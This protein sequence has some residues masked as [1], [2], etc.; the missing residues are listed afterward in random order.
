MNE[1]QLTK[2]LD[3][4]NYESGSLFLIQGPFGD[5]IA[6]LDSKHKGLKYAIG[7]SNGKCRS[8]GLVEGE[9]IKMVYAKDEGCTGDEQIWEFDLQSPMGTSFH[10]TET[11]MSDDE[12]AEWKVRAIDETH[13]QYDKELAARGKM[14]GTF[15]ETL[16]EECDKGEE[17]GDFMKPMKKLLEMAMGFEK[18]FGGD[19]LKKH[20][21]AMLKQFGMSLPEEKEKKTRKS[22]TKK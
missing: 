19:E 1:V 15:F 11:N 22:K 9:G 18:E 14:M 13:P 3:L 6:V 10:F 4:L 5:D 8:L 2:V 12:F 20:G 16:S 21:N 17:D 7:D